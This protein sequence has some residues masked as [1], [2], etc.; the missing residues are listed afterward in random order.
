[1]SQDNLSDQ[2][3]IQDPVGNNEES[4]QPQVEYPCSPTR[5]AGHTSTPQLDILNPV[6]QPHNMITLPEVV[7]K[8]ESLTDTM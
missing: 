4:S 6:T 3:A 8:S 7:V 2:A 5:V 1:P